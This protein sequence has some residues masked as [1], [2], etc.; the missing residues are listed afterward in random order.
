MERSQLTSALPVVATSGGRG[1]QNGAGV[2]YERAGILLRQS[3][4]GPQP[5]L[6]WVADWVV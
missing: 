4:R 1:W 6:E 3:D 5:S 2:E